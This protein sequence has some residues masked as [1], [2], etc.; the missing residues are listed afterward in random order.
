MTQQTYQ[1]STPHIADRGNPPAPKI[2]AAFA[3]V[4]TTVSADRAYA[5]STV[6]LTGLPAEANR[7]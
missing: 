3:S 7:R 6:A 2:Q 1:V 4:S 5:H